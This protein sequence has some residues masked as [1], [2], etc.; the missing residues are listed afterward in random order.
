MTPKV[1]KA[2]VDEKEDSPCKEKR[3]EETQNNGE[4]NAKEDGVTWTS[5]GKLSMAL[6]PPAAPCFSARSRRPRIDKHN[7]TVRTAL[8]VKAWAPSSI[9][10]GSAL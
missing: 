1:N 7:H 3:V 10:S 6:A 2:E 5:S 4:K 9:P 8:G